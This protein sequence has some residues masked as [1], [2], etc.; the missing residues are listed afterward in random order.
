MGEHTRKSSEA[1]WP[2]T[3]RAVIFRTGTETVNAEISIAMIQIWD[4]GLARLGEEGES[5]NVYLASEFEYPADG[6]SENEATHVSHVGHTAA[7]DVG[8]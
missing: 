6:S 8:H 4:G 1:S 3:L 2:G 5:L 7:L